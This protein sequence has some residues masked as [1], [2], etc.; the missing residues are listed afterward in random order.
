MGEQGG[1]RT[2]WLAALSTEGYEGEPPLLQ[3]LGINMSHVQAK[4]CFSYISGILQSVPALN[5]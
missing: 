2:G 5:Q 3:E 4:V 1:L